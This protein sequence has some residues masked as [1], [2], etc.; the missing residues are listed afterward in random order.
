MQDASGLLTARA[1]R[2][3]I[4]ALQDTS[5]ASDYPK[6]LALLPDPSY[7]KR[8]DLFLPWI[9]KRIIAFMRDVY[10]EEVTPEQLYVSSSNTSV[11][12][13][14]ILIGHL[15]LRDGRE[16][17]AFKRSVKA[18][19]SDI[20]GVIDVSVYSMNHNIRCLGAKKHGA[21]LVPL[22]PV[23]AIGE[24]CFADTVSYASW[25]DIP[26]QTILA[27]M[28]SLIPSDTRPM[29]ASR[30]TLPPPRPAPMRTGAQKRPREAEPV[31]DLVLRVFGETNA[32]PGPS[33]DGD[34]TR[35]DMLKNGLERACPT[36]ERHNSNG[37]QVWEEE[38]CIRY[39]CFA[40]TCAHKMFTL[41]PVTPCTTP[42]RIQ[43]LNKAAW[44]EWD[45]TDVPNSLW[46]VPWVAG[47]ST[48]RPWADAPL[49][50]SL[51]KLRVHVFRGEE[52]PQGPRLHAWL[53]SSHDACPFCRGVHCDPFK[54]YEVRVLVFSSAPH[55]KAPCQPN[56]ESFRRAP[57]EDTDE[58]ETLIAEVQRAAEGERLEAAM[59]L[60]IWARSGDEDYFRRE[61]TH[62]SGM[63][64]TYESQAIAI[65]YDSA[66]G[67]RLVCKSPKGD[68]STFDVKPAG[69]L[70]ARDTGLCI[71]YIV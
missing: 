52:G 53:F 17:A 62:A 50:E 10:G 18:F 63:K 45:S 59:R 43:R 9:A 5:C 20:P 71:D 60:L 25:T 46:G 31:N 36:G 68:G 48:P 29:D 7:F 27:H 65:R 70:R 66:N 13:Y 44:R 69:R 54:P 33:R 40:S 6:F 64:Y 23:V 55:L 57:A 11:Q 67:F 26:P 32:L 24:M 51:F 14:H 2:T 19:F 37:F 58:I 22:M 1:T 39:H 15:L 35:Y 16:R 42:P 56:G 41:G 47:E 28:W 4:L 21:S 34:R 8:P 30:M 3:H 61:R 49:L 12:S 38:D